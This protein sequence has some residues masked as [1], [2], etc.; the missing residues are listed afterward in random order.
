M[1]A[2]EVGAADVEGLCEWRVHIEGDA[3]KGLHV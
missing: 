2:C 3:W 1:R